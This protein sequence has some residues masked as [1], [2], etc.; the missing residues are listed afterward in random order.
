MGGAQTTTES[1]VKFT[2][3]VFTFVVTCGIM[4]QQV[5][6]CIEAYGFFFLLDRLW[7]VR[8]ALYEGI[9]RFNAVSGD[10]RWLWSAQHCFSKPI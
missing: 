1:A 5:G 6:L 8:V 4:C 3:G 9:L 2:S 7:P 10:V